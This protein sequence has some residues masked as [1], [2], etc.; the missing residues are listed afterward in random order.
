MKI[1]GM[2]RHELRGRFHAFQEVLARFKDLQ[3]SPILDLGDRFKEF[4]GFIK[5]NYNEALY[6]I[7]KNDGVTKHVGRPS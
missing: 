7:K 6:S 4:E 3:V 5:D 2:G 1:E